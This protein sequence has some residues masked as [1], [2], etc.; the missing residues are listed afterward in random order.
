MKEAKQVIIWRADVRSAG[1]QKLRSGKLMSQAS[2]A[3]IGSFLS[4]AER[5]GDKIIFD[6]KKNDAL[7]AWLEGSFTKITVQCKDE[8]ELVDLYNQAKKAGLP[9]ALITDAGR[10]EFNGIQ[11]KTCMAIGPGDIDEIDKI[12]GDLPLY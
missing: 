8:K 10:T 6:L 12:T 11:T 9:C 5:S 4:M 1:G 3:S 2:H 7:R